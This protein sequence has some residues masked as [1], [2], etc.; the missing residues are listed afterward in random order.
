MRK[1]LIGLAVAAAGFLL[2]TAVAVFVVQYTRYS[3]M[4]KCLHYDLAG[5]TALIQSGRESVA[6]LAID[7]YNRGNAYN[8]TGRH[9]AAIADYVK[10]IALNPDFAAAYG[11]RG[12]AY[13]RDG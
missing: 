3:N 1:F 12:S 6:D 8:R 13:G 9:D 4:T 10:A 11:N 7:Y 2:V 5:C